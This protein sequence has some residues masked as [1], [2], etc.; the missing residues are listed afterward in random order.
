V[1]DGAAAVPYIDAPTLAE[2]L[3]TDL[4]ARRNVRNLIKRR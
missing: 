1:R 3:E 2:V 4:L